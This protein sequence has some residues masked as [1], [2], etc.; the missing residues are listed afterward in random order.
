MGTE[1]FSVP[2]VLLDAANQRLRRDGQSIPLTPKAFAVLRY[3]LER[4]GQ[5][6]TKEELLNAAWPG[7]YVSDAALKVCI[8]RLRQALGD[9]SHPPKYIETVHWRGYRLLTAIPTTASPVPSSKFKVQSPEEG[10]GSQYSVTSSPHENNHNAK[11]EN[12]G[13]AEDL[14]LQALGSPPSP[15]SGLQPVACTFPQH[16]TLSTQHFF[17]P[18]PLLPGRGAELAQ[19]HNVLEKARNRER[20]TVFLTGAAGI[21]KTAIVEAFLADVAKLPHVVTAWGQC[22]EHYGAG[23]SYLPVLEALHRLCRTAGGERLV[24]GLRRHAP[25]WLAQLPPLLSAGERRQLRRETQGAS[26]ERMLRE[27]AEAVETLTE[28]MTLVLV[29]EDLHWSDHATLDLLSF[30]ARRSEPARLLILCVYRPEE[31]IQSGHPLKKIKQD[32]QTHRQCQEMTVPP[33]SLDAIDLYLRKSFPHHAF[34]TALTS[35]LH[36]RTGGNPLFLVNMIE[37]FLARGLI[38]QGESQW[39]LT[40]TVDDLYTETPASIQHIIEAQIDRLTPQERRVLEVASVA[41]MD[42]SAAAVAAALDTDLENIE[43]CCE[44][45]ARRGQFLRAQGVDEW[46]D[47]TVAARYEFMHSLY[48]QAWYER[49]TAGRRVRLHQRIGECSERAYGEQVRQIAAELAVHFERGRDLQRAIRYRYDAADN[50]ARRFG[51]QEAISHL[52][53]GLELLSTSP[54]T[55]ERAQQELA[56]QSA[57]GAAHLATQGYTAPAVEQTYARVH[58]LCRQTVTTSP[59]LASVIHNLWIY[60]LARAELSTAQGLAEQLLH[61]AQ[62]GQ[63]YASL[64]EAERMLGQTFYFLGN[65]PEARRYLERSFTRYNS[66]DYAPH[67]FLYGQDPGVVCLAQNARTLC[68]MGYPEQAIQ[69]AHAAIAL[70]KEIAHSYSLALA[71]YQAAVMYHGMRNIAR[72][73]AIL[74]AMVA[75]SPEHGIPYWLSSMEVLK[76]W[77]LANQGELH[78]GLQM[79]RQGLAMSREVGTAL[80]RAYSLALLAE[81]CGA[82]GAA[83]E[84]LA[85]LREAQ[86]LAGANAGYFYLAEIYRLQ[87]EL[88]LQKGARDSG[89]EAR[90]FSPQAPNPK[91]QALGGVEREAEGYFLKALEI[92]RQQG[93]KLLELRAGVSLSQLWRRQ[94]RATHA[95]QLLAPLYQWFTEG[96]DAVDLREAKALLEELG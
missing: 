24:A 76:G 43:A 45:L 81:I 10:A 86:E 60:H 57:L 41:G 80:N 11:D 65:L 62:H 25:L 79:V 31:L 1:P 63:P 30:L 26:R 84:G 54:S 92:A 53:R 28:T 34:P 2:P 42:F 37:H 33:L 32:L 6:V 89:L 52:L 21:G 71:Q 44:E 4:P 14:R 48:Q 85:L 22:I 29:L 50:A 61:L 66:Q 94:G 9:L 35:L 49:V 13:Q 46:P 73:Q 75:L 82:D 77:A 5:L 93:A 64:I 27:M 96:F 16:S 74:E 40:C 69:Q 88:T 3:L 17:S 55:P 36:K 91:S 67:I 8:R 39:S 83:A 18:T 19:L 38:I 90:S 56:F 7:T 12:S 20:Q 72:M 70:A 23:E 95:R 15:P 51:Y 59:H 87:G 78:A 58:T 68:L 47:G